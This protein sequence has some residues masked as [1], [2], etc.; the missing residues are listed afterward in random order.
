VSI[1]LNDGDEDIFEVGT[2]REVGTVH[3]RRFARIELDADP[4]KA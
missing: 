4:V 1:G 3:E 2:V